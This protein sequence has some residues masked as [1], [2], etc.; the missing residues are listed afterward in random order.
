MNMYVYVCKHME[1]IP[2]ICKVSHSVETNG[3][4]FIVLECLFLIHNDKFHIEA[5]DVVLEFLG[6]LDGQVLQSLSLFGPLHLEFFR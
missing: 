2:Q 6:R 3:C 5:D 4:I 1:S